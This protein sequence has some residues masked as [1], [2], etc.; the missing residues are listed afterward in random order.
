MCYHHAII[1]VII[2]LRLWFFFLEST[3]ISI[4][5]SLLFVF[6]VVGPLPLLAS[7]CVVA[8]FTVRALAQATISPILNAT[9]IHRFWRANGQLLQKLG[10]K[11]NVRKL[12]HVLVNMNALAT[13]FYQSISPHIHKYSIL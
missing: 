13:F 6:T 10:T 8:A 11:K 7:W 12:K 1:I 5:S 4:T 3:A 9:H 2:F